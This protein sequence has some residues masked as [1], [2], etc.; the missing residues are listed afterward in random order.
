MKGEKMFLQSLIL[1]IAL[2]CSAEDLTPPS[3]YLNFDL[4]LNNSEHTLAARSDFTLRC[5]VNGLTV[6]V[7]W[8]SS[9]FRLRYQ[10]RLTDTLV[11]PAAEPRHTG[12]YHCGYRNQSLAHLESWVHI[13]IRDP[14]HHAS[15]FVTPRRIPEMKEGLDFL[16]ECLLTDPSFTDLAFRLAEDSGSGRGLPR[17]MDV[18]FERRRGVLIRDLRL[19]YN[20]VYVCTARKDGQELT[21]SELNLIVI[22]R[23]RS[24]PSVS[25]SQRE[26]V[27][28]KGERFD[29]SCHTS[30]PNHFYNVTWTHP[31]IQMVNVSVQHQYRDKSV[32][33]SSSLSVA[34]V[35]QRHAGIFSCSAT[36]EAGST[37]E[38][39][40]LR[41]PDH[42]YLQVY[43]LPVQHANVSMSPVQRADVSG[44]KARGEL[45]ARTEVGG[46]WCARVRGGEKWR[47]A[48]CVSRVEVYEGQDVNLTFAMEAYPPLLR[49]WWSTPPQ[50]NSTK[51]QES[52]SNI[53]DRYTASILLSRVRHEDRGRFS[54]HFYSLFFNGSLNLDL[55]VYKAPSA[56]VK[57]KNGTLTCSSSGYPLPTI[58]WYICPG[59]MNTCEDNTTFQVTPADR[60]SHMEE[61][62]EEVLNV[63]SPAEDVMVECVASS[64]VGM[65]RDFFISYVPL[66]NKRGI[67]TFFT[68]T[69]IGASAAATVLFLLLLVL[70]YK[71]RQKPKYEI[72]WKIIES[73]HGNSYTF[74]DPT[75]L[76][77][78]QKWEFPRDRLR[79]GAVLGAGAF[80]KVVEATAYGLG[81]EDNVTRVAVK[82][83]KPSAHSEEREALMSELK[84]LS[85]LGFHDN[86]VNLLGACTRGGP[87]LMITEYCS[88]GDLLNFL[89]DHAQDF[90]AAIL[91][92]REVDEEWELYKN[93]AALQARVRSD[94][95]I[96]G[97]SEYQEMQPILFS[98]H[99][100]AAQ[101]GVYT[102]RHTHSCELGNLIHFSYQ[103]AQG[104]DFLSSQNCIHRDVAARNILL[105]E[106]RVA[107]I[108]DFGLARDIRNDDNYV[109]QGNARLPVKWMAP[110][111]I[112]ECIY[113][114]QSDVWSY[115]VLLWE[116][117]SLGQSPYPNMAV[118]SNFYKMIK[119]GRH[120][121]QPDFAPSKMYQL[122][123]RCW[124]LEPTERPTFNTI[125]QLMKRLFTSY[126]DTLPHHTGQPNY[127]NL[128]GSCGEKERREGEEKELKGGQ[129]VAS[130][131][132]DLQEEDEGPLMS[133]K[134]NI[135]HVC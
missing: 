98:D 91:S 70:L 76:P 55:R 131:H 80:G 82:M 29:V 85:H 69:L 4:I 129:E 94:S 34:S 106:H 36:N 15:V 51:H 5:R 10:E 90:V 107:K 96:S 118:D 2:C 66:A 78:N 74:I 77:Y 111:S 92:V 95:G 132:G 24:P 28:L 101:G 114:T 50:H 14:T 3:M 121:S 7:H 119:D 105:T 18:T 87:T 127:S 35:D 40:V 20:G 54:F 123:V 22:A 71:Y 23:L 45:L 120:M 81:T 99:T 56:V 103:V 88:Y 47:K 130:L 86:I 100:N 97:V 59:V 21:S 110:E 49:Q 60:R 122:M 126:N 83:L 75:Q 124:S 65:S 17:G 30:N 117:F 62:V 39:A 89:R 9:A 25:L 37:T 46:A 67:S 1:S 64:H 26:F 135:Y 53:T 79:L 31:H 133:M 84:I 125:T 8:S 6:P 43:L 13:Y 104:M 128:S 38:R 12:T 27:R 41:V 113:T 108:C 68:P 73:N 32:Y 102:D 57:R 52:Y 16:F 58:T 19:A 63:L 115:G 42:P 33:I 11:I 109:V 93:M 116:I 61:E 72:R 48:G 112:F 134:K 44:G